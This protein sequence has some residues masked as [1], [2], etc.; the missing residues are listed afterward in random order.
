MS[1]DVEKLQ[2]LFIQSV[3]G[4]SNS[5]TQRFDNAED[6]VSGYCIDRSKQIKYI[7]NGRLTNVH[8]QHFCKLLDTSHN[9]SR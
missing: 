2:I 6:I 9:M 1:T 5:V 7:V 8:F 3:S 4:L